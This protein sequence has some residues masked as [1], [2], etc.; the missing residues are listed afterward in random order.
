[1]LRGYPPRGVCGLTLRFYEVMDPLAPV[2]KAIRLL[3]SRGVEHAAIVSDDGV[4]LSVLSTKDIGKYVVD[5]FEEAGVVERFDF[6][7]VL[8]TP[9]YEIASEPAYVV[10]EKDLRS[11]A[12]IMAERRI[13]FLPVTDEEGRLKDACTELDYSLELMGDKRPARC[14]ATH[15]I[16]MGDPSDTLI[17]A[18]G[19][20]IEKG[21]RRLPIRQ[22]NE[23]YM[24]TMIG[25]LSAI[26]REPRED[27]LVRE[28]AYYASPAPR[29]S[30]ENASIGEA[31]ELIASTPERALLLVDAEQLARAILTARDLLT[32]YIDEEQRRCQN[33]P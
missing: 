26:A 15:E 24:A 18:L 8:E 14:Y 17:E 29:L 28:L 20:M 6:K 16:V 1:M 25:L 10:R 12:K 31:A 30:Y 21:F 19:I 2:E 32:A 23:Y 4:L 5:A 33:Q 7:A 3:A 9:V 27:T 13:G 22:G 11:C